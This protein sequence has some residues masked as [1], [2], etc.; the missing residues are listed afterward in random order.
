MSSLSFT[1]PFTFKDFKN[2]PPRTLGRVK[3]VYPRSPGKTSAM[4]V[5]IFALRQTADVHVRRMRGRYI[6]QIK[7]RSRRQHEIRKGR[8]DMATTASA[9]RRLINWTENRYGFTIRFD[10]PPVFTPDA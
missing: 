2:N 10:P 4:D 6:H 5:L 7:G 8:L 9:E 1:L 3:F